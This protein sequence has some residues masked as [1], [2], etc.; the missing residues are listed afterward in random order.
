[1]SGLINCYH[2]LGRYS[3]QQTHDT[4]LIF[5]SRK[6]T[7]TL[8]ANCCMKCQSLFSEKNGKKKKNSKCRLLKFLPSMLS[9]KNYKGSDAYVNQNWNLHSLDIRVNLY[10]KIKKYHWL[11]CM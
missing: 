3:R 8:H 2:S 11:L 4:F 7:L 9:V 1:M 5:F 6:F 10:D